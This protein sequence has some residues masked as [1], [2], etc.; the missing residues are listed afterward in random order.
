M[1]R[2]MDRY[3]R[4]AGL[5]TKRKR[6]PRKET[7]LEI[8]KRAFSYER[9]SGIVNVSTVPLVTERWM[10]G[11]RQIISFM[12]TLPIWLPE[13]KILEALDLGFGFLAEEV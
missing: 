10:D 11:E 9:S 13:E 8:V 5:D 12:V 1:S 6:T 7:L 4:A 3:R 2:R